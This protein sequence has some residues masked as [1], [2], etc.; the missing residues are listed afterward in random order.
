MAKPNTSYDRGE[1]W[2]HKETL[3]LIEVWGEEA[4]QHRLMVSN[5]NMDVFEEIAAAVRLRTDSERTASQ[6]RSR[7]KRLKS[8]Y[9]RTI[10][11]ASDGEKPLKKFAFFDEL[12]RIFRARQFMTTDQHN[13]A[14]PSSQEI[15]DGL[16]NE[17][18]KF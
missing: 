2:S 5:R 1:T 18:G 8:D 15:P 6:C 9:T 4:I 12:D 13:A 16:A 11:Q 10:K 17:K 7:V 14:V 3:A